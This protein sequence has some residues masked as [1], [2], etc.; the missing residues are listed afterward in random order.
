MD[1]DTHALQS[2][3]NRYRSMGD[4]YP[5]LRHALVPLSDDCYPP[6]FCTSGP[7]GS[8]AD[9]IAERRDGYEVLRADEWCGVSDE[10]VYHVFS[11]QEADEKG[12]QDFEELALETT[13]ELRCH[14]P[15]LLG[16]LMGTAPGFEWMS[17][18]YNA[19]RKKKYSTRVVQRRWLQWIDGKDQTQSWCGVD[20][21][22]TIT[23]TLSRYGIQGEPQFDI[24]YEDLDTNVWRASALAIESIVTNFTSDPTKNPT[25]GKNSKKR[26]KRQLS[27]HSRVVANTLKRAKKS[28]D[29]LTK[30]Q[31]IADYCDKHPEVKGST[32]GRELSDNPDYWK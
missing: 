7:M 25:T 24:P 9:A 26:R 3:S 6:E 30:A 20:V 21:E 19:L 22:E 13:D 11:G 27:D 5:T 32:I 14:M 4:L 2:L 12:L 28:E 29:K 10:P 31:A 8:M 1:M 16:S 15:S 23:R 18:V 17:V